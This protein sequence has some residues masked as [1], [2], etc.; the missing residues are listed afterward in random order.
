MIDNYTSYWVIG[1]FVWNFNDSKQIPLSF[2]ILPLL[3]IFRREEFWKKKKKNIS[4]EKIYLSKEIFVSE[5]IYNDKT[6]VFEGKI[7]ERILNN[8]S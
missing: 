5:K 6:I 8:I 7:R 1:I 4:L 2:A 3:F